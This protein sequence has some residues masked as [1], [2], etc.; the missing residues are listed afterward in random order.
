MTLNS[1][2][3]DELEIRLKSLTSDLYDM[4]PEPL[5]ILRNALDDLELIKLL[6]GMDVKDYDEIL[7][8]YDRRDVPQFTPEAAVPLNNGKIWIRED[9]RKLDTFLKD[10]DMDVVTIAELLCRTVGSIESKGAS[11]VHEK[12]NKYRNNLDL[13]LKTYH[14]KV[15]QNLNALLDFLRKI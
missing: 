3:I 15:C 6:D 11:L 7:S 1:D 13:A 9:L 2:D 5:R 4:K 14:Y 8:Q 12:V 10:P